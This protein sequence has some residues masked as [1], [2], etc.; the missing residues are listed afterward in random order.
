MFLAGVD[1]LALV[2]RVAHLLARAGGQALVRVDATFS[3]SISFAN[4][5]HLLRLLTIFG[6]HTLVQH[7]VH[8]AAIF[9]TP[10]RALSNP[11][12]MMRT[13]CSFSSN[14]FWPPTNLACST[15]I[16]GLAR[17]GNH[18]SV[19]I[20]A[21]LGVEVEKN[22]NGKKVKVEKDIIGIIDA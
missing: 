2:L 7:E 8:C 13:T 6:G 16:V 4:L 15:V 3:L 18:T 19:I 17:M 10:A 12:T 5:P 21:N 14:F 9:T 1:W 22:E 11:W 20:G